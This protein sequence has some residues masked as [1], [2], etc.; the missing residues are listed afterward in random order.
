[1]TNGG[2]RA[3]SRDRERTTVDPKIESGASDRTT[4]GGGRAGN[5]SGGDD[6]EARAAVT[7]YG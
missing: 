7:Q 3:T 1:V 2:R 4:N 5:W 6:R